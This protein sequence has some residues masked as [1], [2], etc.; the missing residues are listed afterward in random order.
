MDRDSLALYHGVEIPGRLIL[1]RDLPVLPLLHERPQY[2]RMSQ[3]QGRVFELS[4][5]D[6]Y[7]FAPVKFLVVAYLAFT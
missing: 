2:H 3:L 7:W 4:F 1:L 5:N 6:N